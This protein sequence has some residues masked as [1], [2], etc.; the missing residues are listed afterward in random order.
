VATLSSAERTAVVDVL[1]DRAIC[2]YDERQLLASA[3]RKLLPEAISV[4]QQELEAAMLIAVGESVAYL[5]R[6]PPV[7]VLRRAHPIRALE[8][9]HKGWP[10]LHLDEYG[11]GPLLVNLLPRADDG[12]VR[13]VA[14]LRYRGH[15]RHSELLLLDTD[16]PAGLILAGAD[17]AAWQAALAFV[18]GS[19]VDDM[20]AP[21]L[22]NGKHSNRLS[23]TEVA[24]MA[25]FPRVPGPAYLASALFRRHRLLRDSQRLTARG[26]SRGWVWEWSAGPSPAAVAGKLTDPLFGLPFPVTVDRCDEHAG[27]ILGRAGAST[28]AHEREFIEIYLRR[29]GAHDADSEQLMREA[30]DMPFSAWADWEAARQEPERPAAPASSA[31]RLGAKRRAQYMGEERAAAA[32]GVT[33]DGR[34]GLDDCSPAQ[35]ALRALLAIHTFN[36]GSIGAPPCRRA[37]SVILCY[38]LTISP[39]FDD[40]VIFADAPS[41]VVDRLICSSTLG[42]PGL[43]F[44]ARQDV[45]TH[46]LVH[47]PT[48]ATM[49]ITR[50]RERDIP[51]RR[52]GL[53]DAAA[54]RRGMGL[55]EAERTDLAAVPPAS[56][57]MQTLLA[58]LF[59]RLASRSPS[60]DWAI[61]NWSYDPL[62]RPRLPWTLDD[63]RRLWGANNR[64][65]LCWE[66]YP[67]AADIVAS[68]TDPFAGIP[69]ATIADAK[70][71]HYTITL[72]KARMALTP[73]KQVWQ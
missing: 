15:R 11:L 7:S 14:G 35:R 62:N 64:W 59:V 31:V 24:H 48:G 53:D 36:S 50:H 33:A 42:L 58:G 30:V 3:R 1:H 4:G 6:R 54:S 5:Q 63:K 44:Q 68:L 57:A 13:G 12:E 39:R 2:H 61:G 38:S 25:Q 41:N 65:E 47:L 32:A 8:L 29:E 27:R 66:G 73:W 67:Y 52:G 34:V 51:P 49:T 37:V 69:G 17:R 45:G 23:S 55:A 43:R 19:F 16:P 60:R 18:A 26:R 46:R 10:V 22:W 28:A 9:P 20:P 72:G 21:W 71:P 70:D 40:L 56:D